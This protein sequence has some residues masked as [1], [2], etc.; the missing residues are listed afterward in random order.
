MIPVIQE[1]RSQQQAGKHENST[2]TAVV[3]ETLDTDGYFSSRGYR[4]H[5]PRP[6]SPRRGRV[7][8]RPSA[9]LQLR[10]QQRL[11]PTVPSARS[12]HRHHRDRLRSPRRGFRQANVPEVNGGGGGG[13]EQLPVPSYIREEN[14]STICPPT[15]L[16]GSRGPRRNAG[17]P[18][19]KSGNRH[20]G[21]EAA[22]A[23]G[24]A[25]L[26]RVPGFAPG[27]EG[28]GSTAVGE[29]RAYTS[30]GQSLRVKG[31][32]RSG[33]LLVGS[34]GAHGVRRAV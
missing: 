26:P 5:S 10:A 13:A 11:E 28:E 17:S 16:I 25:R 33:V 34:Q 15:F 29:E 4:R 12:H 22:A 1:H 7:R 21:R 2:K 31:F 3:K 14:A 30:A 27:R 18:P 32:G 23:E 19:K 24:N 6:F 20:H 8:S 9:Q